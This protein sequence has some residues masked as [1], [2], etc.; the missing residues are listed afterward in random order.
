M[1]CTEK[2]ENGELC[3]KSEIV[4]FTCVECGEL[5]NRGWF[6]LRS[7]A[8]RRRAGVFQDPL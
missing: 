1:G 7:S 2:L 5:N 4:T 3:G 8:E 6:M